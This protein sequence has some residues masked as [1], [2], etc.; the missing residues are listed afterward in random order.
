MKLSRWHPEP[1]EVRFWAK[2]NKTSECWEWTAAVGSMGYGKFGVREGLS[3]D[4]HRYAWILTAGHPGT[5]Q[6]NHRC[7]NRL[8]V[9]PDHLYLGSQQR[10]VQDEYDR[11]RRPKGERSHLA[12]LTEVQVGEIRTEYQRGLGRIL[13]ARYGVNPQTIYD[14]VN[15]KSWAHVA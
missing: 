3:M 10:N 13:A 11:N 7:D 12:K 6:V 9:R 8:C 14:I 15:R 2:V 1:P 5:Q 4:S